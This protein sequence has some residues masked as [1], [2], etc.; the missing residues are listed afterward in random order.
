MIDLLKAL[1]DD[2]RMRIFNL[3]RISELCVCEIETILQI[4][5]SN[6]S[7]HLTKLKQ[8]NII[9]SSKEAQWVH[10]TVTE[11]FVE[12]NKDLVAYLDFQMTQV[13]AYIQDV[14]RYKK[15]VEKELTCTDI[16]E[17]ADRVFE[18]IK[19]E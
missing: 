2:N 12:K 8:A 18:M 3:L 7:R 4:S 11:E 10:Y 16:R 1:A 17:D 9:S 6:T 5:Q 14:T 19:A 15:Y 13:P